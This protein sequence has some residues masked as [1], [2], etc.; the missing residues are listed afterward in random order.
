VPRHGLRAPPPRAAPS[1]SRADPTDAFPSQNR[2]D[3]RRPARLR[4][5]RR[6][7]ERRGAR[8]PQPGSTLFLVWQQQRARGEIFGDFDLGRD[9]RAIFEQRPDDIFVIKASDWIGR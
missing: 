6:R 8:R 7:A 1:P 9:S 3:A 2:T 4:R 5:P